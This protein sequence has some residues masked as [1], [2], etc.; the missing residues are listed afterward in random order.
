MYIVFT[1]EL[2]LGLSSRGHHV[3][4]GSPYPI[5]PEIER[6]KSINY[7]DFETAALTESILVEG[8]EKQENL[9]ENVYREIDADI[10]T[11]IDAQVKIA[12]QAQNESFNHDR[13]QKLIKQGAKFDVAIVDFLTYDLGSV[14]AVEHFEAPIIYYVGHSTDPAAD[15]LMGNPINPSYLVSDMAKVTQGQ[16]MDLWNRLENTITT[17]FLLLLKCT[18]ILFLYLNWAWAQMVCMSK[19]TSRCKTHPPYKKLGE[20]Y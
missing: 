8:Y 2:A 14:L 11:S 9:F 16:V 3:T 15:L 17:A 19:D 12:L 6:Q 7:I 18:V 4:F 1:R 13:V 10:L 5:P 20:I